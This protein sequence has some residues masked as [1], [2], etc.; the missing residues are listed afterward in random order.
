MTKKLL[1]I[2]FFA[3]LLAA[4]APVTAAP[5]PTQTSTLQ[6][7]P[8]A[9]AR[10]IESTS[11]ATRRPFPTVTLTFIPT[12]TPATPLAKSTYSLNP[13]S[14]VQADEIIASIASQLNATEA[15]DSE[16]G[17]YGDVYHLQKYRYLAFAEQEALLRFKDA[18]QAERWRWNLA[19]DQAMADPYAEDE[20][21]PELKTYAS[22]M[23][24]ALNNGTTNPDD[25][26]AWFTKHETRITAKTTFPV[27]PPG[28]QR[29]FVVSLDDSA[30]FWM[31]QKDGKFSVVGLRSS[32]FY[33]RD[34][35]GGSYRFLDLTGDGIPE[36]IFNLGQ[37][38]CCGFFTYSY[39]YDI[40]QGVPRQLQ[41]HNTSGVQNNVNSDGESKLL[42]L[43]AG[44]AL[45][46]FTFESTYG[47][48]YSTPCQLKQYDKYIWN[49]AQ[50]ELV[51]T[52]YD[53]DPSGKEI[54]D[55][56]TS[57]ASDKP[58]MEVVVKAIRE[59]DRQHTTDQSRLE[60]FRDAIRYR[61]G[62]YYAQIGDVAKAQKTL[63]DLLTQPAMPAKPVSKWSSAA[64]TFLENYQ[65]SA[66][67]YKICAKVDVCDSATALEAL[68]HNAS[69]EQWLRMKAYLTDAGVSVKSSGF[70]DFDKNDQMDQWL[71]VHLPGVDANQFWLVT[72]TKSD[73]Q[74]L[75]VTEISGT[76]PTM[77]HFDDYNLGLTTEVDAK[78]VFSLAWLKIAGKPY[79]E[80]RTPTPQKE[81]YEPSEEETFL[82]QALERIHADLLLG[83]NPEEIRAQLLAM[84]QTPAF[85]CR[86]LDCDKFYYL[87]GLSNELA[88]DQQNAIKNYLQVWQDYPY[89]FFTIMA[90]IKLAH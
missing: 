89:S 23:E 42:G 71:V 74:G 7:T 36:L 61:L 67:T 3:I 8:S 66:D 12:L 58:E 52:W 63:A 10:P 15:E 59:I 57:M 41:F 29:S 62:E 14:P 13:A 33:Y 27:P 4:C 20:N 54:C 24:E 80:K 50:F 34:F 39:V 55:F 53:I 43:D 51:D 56:A 82:A 26:P 81:E 49:G 70:F 47:D 72:Q 86:R 48:H 79:I 31:T 28:F 69:S 2:C 90:R 44:E 21:A 85:D 87:L 78:T 46:G 83:E 5:L 35:A 73:P 38:Y 68:I 22:L 88:G 1:T 16:G 18:P 37:S 75:F 64:K 65:S 11:T 76:R 77:R 45:H 60:E 17:V 9:T 25:L 40:S 32:L 6:P 84:Q 30:F 19:Y